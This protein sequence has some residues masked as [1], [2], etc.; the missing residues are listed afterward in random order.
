[1]IGGDGRYHNRTAVQI[2]LKMAAANG[3]GRIVV[4]QD[5]LLST[6]AASCLIRK[7]RAFGGLI[8]SASHNPGGPHGDFGIKYNVGERR[9]GAREGHRGDLS[10]HPADRVSTG[11]WTSRDVALDRLGETGSATP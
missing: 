6:P 8:L 7:R 5:G 10:P 3:F 11:S 1:M 9:P 4:G 2:I